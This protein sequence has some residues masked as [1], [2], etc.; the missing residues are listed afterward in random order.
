MDL[1]VVKDSNSATNPYGF[2][3]GYNDDR[4]HTYYIWESGGRHYV[5]FF[6]GMDEFHH[7]VLKELVGLT[8]R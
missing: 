3:K 8:K 5:A 1:L 7:E 2:D 4:T 6:R